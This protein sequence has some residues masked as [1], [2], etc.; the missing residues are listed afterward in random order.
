MV[1]AREMK[2]ILRNN[3]YEYQRCNAD[4]CRCR[5]MSC[6]TFSIYQVLPQLIELWGFNVQTDV[7]AYRF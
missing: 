5:C 3:G 1:D 2:K 7:E 4:I 6:G